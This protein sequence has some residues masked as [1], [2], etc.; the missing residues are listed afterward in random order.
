VGGWM[1]R[2]E[3]IKEKRKEKKK[4]NQNKTQVLSTK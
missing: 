2:Q 4:E 3:K 1:E